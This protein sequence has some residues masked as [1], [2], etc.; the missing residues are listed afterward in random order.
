[1][2]KLIIALLLA[3]IVPV[4]AF[5]D[6]TWT[7]TKNGRAVTGQQ[8]IS[9]VVAIADG[10]TGYTARVSSTGAV[11][12]I[13]HP[14]AVTALSG[15]DGILLTGAYRVYSITVAGQLTAA[16]DRVD[17]YD[18]LSAT[19]TPK[20]EISVGTAKGTTQL[21]FPNGVTFAT[22]VFEDQSGNNMLVSVCY[23]N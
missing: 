15:L 9:N 13:D 23:D 16:G 14:C 5:A 21:V 12:T 2:N 17:I 20:Y 22:G 6:V 1:M 8:G 10:S 7:T 4:M 18:A 19:G 3:F 11:S